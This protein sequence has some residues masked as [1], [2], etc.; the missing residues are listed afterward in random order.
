MNTPSRYMLVDQSVTVTRS[1]TTTAHPALGMYAVLQRVTFQRQLYF[2]VQRSTRFYFQEG[3][4][5]NLYR[6]PVVNRFMFLQ[7]HL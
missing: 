7:T 1:P 5:R 2:E 4:I 6:G 3:A